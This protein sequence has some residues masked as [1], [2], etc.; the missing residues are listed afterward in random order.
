MLRLAIFFRCATFPSFPWLFRFK[1]IIGIHLLQIVD[2][3]FRLFKPRNNRR[4]HV[5]PLGESFVE[6][7]GPYAVF[8]GNLMNH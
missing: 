4:V 6:A 8:T 3:L 1:S 7:G 5:G 2:S